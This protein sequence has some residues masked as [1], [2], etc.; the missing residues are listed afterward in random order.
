ML[1][2]LGELLLESSSRY[3]DEVAF[4][5]RRGF[6]LERVTFREASERAR[7]VAAW[8][9]ASGLVPGDRIIVW[10]PNMPEYAVLYFGAWLAGIVV[11]PVD[12]RTKQDVLDRF[13]AAAAPRLGLKSRSLDGSFAPPVATTVALEDLFELAAT[14][15]PLALPP[16]VRPDELCEIAFT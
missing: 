16:A 1:Q 12:V 6:R 4:Q 9:L 7:Q 11:V 10:S 2:N 8:L 13:V 3:G 14:T 15:A 5:I